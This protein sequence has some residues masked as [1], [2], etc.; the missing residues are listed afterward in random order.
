MD[1]GGGSATS[2][3]VDATR[4]PGHSGGGKHDEGNRDGGGGGQRTH[5]DKHKL[6]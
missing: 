1:T 3:A 5:E 4:V 2:V 6:E